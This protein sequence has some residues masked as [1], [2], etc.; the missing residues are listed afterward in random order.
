METINVKP[1]TKL[2]FDKER[3]NLRS[4]EGRYVEQDEMLGLLIKHWRKGR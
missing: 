3:L 2:E 4:R 1:E